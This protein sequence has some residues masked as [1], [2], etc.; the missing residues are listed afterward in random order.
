MITFAWPIRNKSQVNCNSKFKYQKQYYWPFLKGIHRWQVDSPH[1][2]PWIRIFVVNLNKLLYRQWGCR[3]FD[4]P[5]HSWK[6]G[7]LATIFVVGGSEFNLSW[8]S[9]Y[10]TDDTS[11]KH[12]SV[13]IKFAG[14]VLCD[15][16][17][18]SVACPRSWRARS[19]SFGKRYI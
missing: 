12:I 17:S 3:W 4:T 5:W 10:K 18:V 6:F 14:S 16:G 19:L 2:G 7:C 11:G 9:N 1:T 15:S 8:R 13:L